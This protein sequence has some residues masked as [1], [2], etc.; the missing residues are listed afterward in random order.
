MSNSQSLRF[1]SHLHDYLVANDLHV[2]LDKV[3][4]GRAFIH[5]ICFAFCHWVVFIINT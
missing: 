5:I 1:D 4:E 3:Y 2:R